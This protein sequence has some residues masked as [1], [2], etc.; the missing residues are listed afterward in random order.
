METK[1][2]DDP[3]TDFDN[4]IR[5]VDRLQEAINFF[6]SNCWLKSSDETLHHAENLLIKSMAKLEDFFRHTLTENRLT[7]QV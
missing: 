2:A 5:R 7:N 3:A 6:E 1:V 4:Y